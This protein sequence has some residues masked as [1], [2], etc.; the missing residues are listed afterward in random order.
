MRVSHFLKELRFFNDF[1][2]AGIAL[3]DK[4]IFK[5]QDWI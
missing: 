5:F 2:I 1:Y 4:Q 3:E